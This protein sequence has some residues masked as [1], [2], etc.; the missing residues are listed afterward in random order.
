MLKKKNLK[1][2]RSAF[3]L[4]PFVLSCLFEYIC[5][6]E[7]QEVVALLICDWRLSA[8]SGWTGLLSGFIAGVGRFVSPCGNVC[9]VCVCFGVVVL[10]KQFV[11]ILDILV[12]SNS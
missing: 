8:W 3:F 11:Y 6:L 2:T 10:C 7:I 12:L 4:E 5:V 1:K 9:I